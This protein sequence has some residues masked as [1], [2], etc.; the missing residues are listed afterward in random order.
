MNKSPE[1]AAM[2]KAKI[3]LMQSANSVFFTS[4]CFS[5]KHIWDSSIKTMATFGKTVYYNP[6]YFLSLSTQQQAGL[7]LRGTFHIIFMHDLR[8]GTREENKWNVAA[9]QVVNLMLTERG[10]Q[11][12]PHQTVNPNFVNLTVEQVY[13]LLTDED[14]KKE[15]NPDGV[16]QGQDDGSSAATQEGDIQDIV[17]RS[18]MQSKMAGEDPGNIPGQCQVMLDKLMNTQLPWPTILRKY[19]K[20]LAKED[21]TFRKPNRRFFPEFYLP[22]LHSEK[23]MD[24]SVAIDVS[25]SVSDED[26]NS[27][28]SELVSVFKMMNPNK[29][30]MISFD[31][32]IRDVIQVKN[33]KELMS[34]PFT[35]RG[36]TAIEPVL[37]WVDEN[38][39]ELLL[40]FTDGEFGMPSKINTKSDIIWLI[41]NNP[42][43]T[44]PHGKV[45][46]YTL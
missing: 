16:G 35:G 6:E 4:A 2:L 42:S 5:L 20:S 45:I 10:F 15:P 14:E 13:D 32:S 25:G 37:K 11:M 43:F 41:Y 44:A 3:C 26:F 27:I 22:S 28:I 33:L 34:T 31:T 24:L 19:L 36:G 21:Y 39:P 38:K 30:D 46:H 17:T 7:M 40:I 1:D 23:C 12:P 8:R 18:A 29:I 9:T